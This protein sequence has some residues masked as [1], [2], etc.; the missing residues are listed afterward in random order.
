MNN[1]LHQFLHDHSIKIIDTNKQCYRH[2]K[3]NIQYFQYSDD[4]NKIPPDVSFR[5]ETEP[6]YTVELA[7]SELE[8]I[9]KFE[10]EVFN[11]MKKYNHYG[12]FESLMAQKTQETYLRDQYPAVKK[13]YEQYSLMLQLAQAGEL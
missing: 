7:K 2:N 3:M 11:N 8:S 5:L 12:L 10:A 13:A 6:L 4:Y 1:D 9:A